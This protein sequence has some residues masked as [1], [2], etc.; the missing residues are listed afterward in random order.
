MAGIH[1]ALKDDDVGGSIIGGDVIV[2][3]LYYDGRNQS[4]NIYADSQDELELLAKEK[5]EE[6]KA[7]CGHLFKTL[8]PNLSAWEL[9]IYD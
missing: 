1:D 2:G 7:E 8:Y 5:L 9:R 3:A 4:G 6:I